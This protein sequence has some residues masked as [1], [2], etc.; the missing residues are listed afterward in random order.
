MVDV[1]K[2]LK[3]LRLQLGLTQKQLAERMG[4][5]TSVISYYEL[6]ERCPSPEVLI[7]LANIFHVSTDYLL[8]IDNMKVLNIS[9]LNEEEV[10]SIQYMIDTFKKSRKIKDD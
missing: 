8:G 1:G 5:T 10:K 6:D 2:K 3:N 4:V 9:E 7:R